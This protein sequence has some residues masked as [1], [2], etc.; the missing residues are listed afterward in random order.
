MKPKG[1]YFFN[2]CRHCFEAI[3]YYYQN[4]GVLVRPQDIPMVEFEKEVTFFQLGDSVL[5]D[6][7]IEEEY[8]FDREEKDDEA[9]TD[10]GAG[11]IFSFNRFACVIRAIFSKFN[12]LPS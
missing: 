12:I 2:R 8:H 10:Y 7:K 1:E 3:L 5:R 9:S 6:L 4:G 11:G